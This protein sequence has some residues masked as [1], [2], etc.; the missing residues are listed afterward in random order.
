M[1]M[2]MVVVVMIIMKKRTRMKKIMM[3]PFRAVPLWFLSC[4]LQ[5][6]NLMFF[7][8]AAK[9]PTIYQI[10]PSRMYHNSAAT[11]RSW[12]WGWAMIHSSFGQRQTTILIVLFH[13]RWMQ[14]THDDAVFPSFFSSYTAYSECYRHSNTSNCILRLSSYVVIRLIAKGPLTMEVGNLKWKEYGLNFWAQVRN[15][16]CTFSIT[17]AFNGSL[18]RFSCRVQ[19]FSLVAS[20]CWFLFFQSTV[21]FLQ[22]TA[23]R[24][25]YGLFMMS[26]LFIQG[27]PRAY[28][29]RETRP[30][31]LG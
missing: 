7:L 20:L 25:L 15:P 3:T 21:S 18:I 12:F 29:Y 14:E 27:V 31:F 10:D 8:F 24:S 19:Q 17:T 6:M 23:F 1:I 26:T 9:M 13:F 4:Y 2:M 5:L 30:I 22:I 16:V 11:Y 28:S